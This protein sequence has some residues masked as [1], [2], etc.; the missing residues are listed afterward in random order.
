MPIIR[1]K[2]GLVDNFTQIPN[3]WLRD[4]NLSLKSI[5]LLAQL[6]S[7]DEGWQVT[8]KSL[9]KA[10]GCG[11]DYIRGAVNELEEAGYL[12]REQRRKPNSQFGEV[13]WITQEPSS[14]FPLSEKPLSEKPISENPMHKN[15]IKKNTID[16]NKIQKNFELFW[17]AYPRKVGQGQAERAFSKALRANLTEADALAEQ[18]IQGAENLALDPNLPPAQFIPYPATWLNRSGWLDEPYPTRELTTD[19]KRERDLAES[20]AKAERE[21]EYTR[22]MLKEYEA[23]ESYEIVKCDHGK[24]LAMCYQCSKKLANE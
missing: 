19:E 3:E 12:R 20:R 13:V 2:L 21:R 8:I 6:S 18:I 9:A 4:S 23:T 22:A 24:T 5:G 7:H 11:L 15:T 17:K 14:G 1:G 16:K 10:N